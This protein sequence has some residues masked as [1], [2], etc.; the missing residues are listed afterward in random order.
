[1]L[2]LRKLRYQILRLISPLFANLK[3]SKSYKITGT[4]NLDKHPVFKNPSAFPYFKIGYKRFK[5]NL[6]K[7]VYTQTAKTYYKFGDGDYHFLRG[8]QYGSAAP[9]NRALGRELNPEELGVFQARA[10]LA[11][12][13]MCEIY[14]Y[15]RLDFGK[16]IQTRK[17]V[18]PAEYA[19][20]AV[21]SRWIFHEFKNNIGLIGSAQ[22]LDLIKEMMAFREYQDYLGVEHFTDY[23]KIPQKFSC[24]DLPRRIEELR[25]QLSQSKSKIFLLGV[26][27]LKSGILSELPKFKQAVYLDV[28]TGID[29][30]AGIIDPKRPYF[31]A[32]TNYFIPNHAL[33]HQLDLLNYNYENRKP[34]INES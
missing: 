12:V 1:M 31:G 29:A 3:Y 20:A 19:Y 6:S 34:L 22:K 24:D 14:P 8:N 2:I 16:V 5:K 4:L 28:G 26:G 10:Q 33:Y 9:G 30:I 17:K 23:I 13:Y 11:D 15:I 32:W 7:N 25:D 21:S 18:I 27:H